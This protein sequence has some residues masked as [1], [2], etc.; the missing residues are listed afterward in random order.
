MVFLFVVNHVHLPAH[1]PAPGIIPTLRISGLKTKHSWSKSGGQPPKPNPSCSF[2]PR[3]F[4][5]HG[6]VW[7]GHTFVSFQ[8]LRSLCAPALALALSAEHEADPIVRFRKKGQKSINQPHTYNH[9]R[10]VQV[11]TVS[12][13]N[14]LS[15]VVVPSLS[16]ALTRPFPSRAPS[17]SVPSRPFPKFR[18]ARLT[19]S[20]GPSFARSRK[21]SCSSVGEHPNH[22]FEV[23]LGSTFSNN[24]QGRRPS[25]S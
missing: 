5:R 7:Q 13:N 23:L 8:W 1:S 16:V 14:V 2:G 10:R 17:F 21:R 4:C 19:C 15:V 11:I 12:H 20:S 24:D 6:A 25:K 9:G 3:Q 22:D 18:G